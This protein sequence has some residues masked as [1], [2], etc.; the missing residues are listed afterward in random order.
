MQTRITL[1][2]IIALLGVAAI[3]FWVARRRQ[4]QMKSGV[5]LPARRLGRS[6]VPKQ[7]RDLLPMAQKW[8]I[9]DDKIRTELH[10]KATSEEKQSL[11]QALEGRT[12]AISQWL[13]TCVK[14]QMSKEAVAYMYLLIGLQEMGIYVEPGPGFRK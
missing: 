6:K 8:G 3:L 1:I 2:F 11:K 7:F 14:G 13:D 5:S 12:E 9:Q 10:S 4:D